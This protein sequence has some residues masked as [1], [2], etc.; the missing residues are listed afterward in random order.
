M[1]ILVFLV[2]FKIS[3]EI[4]LRF[5]RTYEFEFKD[6]MIYN[7]LLNNYIGTEICLGEGESQCLTLNIETKDYEFWVISAKSKHYANQKTFNQAQSDTFYLKNTSPSFFS[8]SKIKK[9]YQSYDTLIINSGNQLKLQ[10]FLFLL[11]DEYDNVP[12]NSG[13]LGLGV[14]PQK[15]DVTL[16]ISF[17]VQLRKNKMIPSYSFAFI[18]DTNKDEEN[19]YKSFESGQLIIGE[20]P[21]DY[22]SELDRKGLKIQYENI[23]HNQMDEMMWGLKF[24]KVEV[25]NNFEITKD[26]Q[27]YISI[28]SGY[29]LGP[30]SYEKRIKEVFFSKWNKI[31]KCFY[32]IAESTYNVYYCDSDI[33]L[34]EFPDLVFKKGNYNI[35]LTSKDLFV[36]Y[37]KKKIFLVAFPI[38]YNLFF[39]LD[40]RFGAPFLK[41][42]PTVFDLDKKVVGFYIDAKLVQ[43]SFID[44]MI[45]FFKVVI[46]GILIGAGLFLTIFLFAKYRKKRILKS[47]KNIYYKKMQS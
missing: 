37:N 41:A 15:V 5:Q 13:I 47:K 38:H 12:V 10:D 43:L 28:E 8:L 40:W 32:D 11:V 14:H 36:N 19:S 25:G 39:G 3:M 9:C 6:Y 24:D 33:N 21:S 2:F 7:N 30:S 31:S 1:N 16:G 34:T 4:S 35:T 22:I 26:T 45:V 20:Y 18:Y 23:I 27:A 17:I 29:I 42:V 46:I 44:I